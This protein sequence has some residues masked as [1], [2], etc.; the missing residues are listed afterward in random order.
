[1]NESHD[2]QYERDTSYLFG[3]LYTFGCVTGDMSTK[4]DGVTRDTGTEI[5]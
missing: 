3:A 5:Y 1:M 2:S 4:N